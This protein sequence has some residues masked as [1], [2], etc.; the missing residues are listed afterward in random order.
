M[1]KTYFFVLFVLLFATITFAQSSPPTSWDTIFVANLE[2]NGPYEPTNLDN[3]V[4]TGYDLT[5]VNYDEDGYQQI[6][7]TVTHGWYGRYESTS[8]PSENFCFT[9]CSY[10]N[11]DN[12]FFPCNL[13]NRNWLIMPPVTISG[14]NAK[15]E[16]KSS[17]YYGPFG[18]DGY[19]VM[20]STSSNLIESFTDTIFKAAE[21][22]KPLATFGLLNTERYLYSDGYLHAN[23]YTSNEY[24][25]LDLDIDGLSFWHG[26]LEPHSADLSAYTGQT[27]YIAFLHDS[28]CD[29]QLQVDDIVVID[30]ILSAIDEKTD[31]A[32]FAVHPNPVEEIAILD[33]SFKKSTKYQ[34]TI[35]DI[36]GKIVQQCIENKD[37]QSLKKSLNLDLK[38]LPSGTYFCNLTTDKGHVS[39]KIVKM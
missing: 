18:V 9:S 28:Q 3:S 12:T 1:K 16:W 23:E 24:Y 15:L 21:M 36:H 31:I 20:V 7:D 30:N 17:S 34:V 6:C 2:G 27:I 10:I 33:I 32:Q 29:F 35:T 22:L 14:E 19:K 26:I 5:W 37:A 8:A 4:P 38:N 39:K 11:G 25:F 13:K